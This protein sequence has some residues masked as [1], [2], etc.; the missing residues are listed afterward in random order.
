MQALTATE[1]VEVIKENVPDLVH[2]EDSA[3]MR[4]RLMAMDNYVHAGFYFQKAADEEVTLHNV[5]G[6]MK[7]FHISNMVD[8]IVEHNSTRDASGWWFI[9]PGDGYNKYEYCHYF[10]TA[11]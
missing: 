9:L 2:A 11:K 5:N 1:L 3:A 6:A 8:T 4:L 7:D 10:V